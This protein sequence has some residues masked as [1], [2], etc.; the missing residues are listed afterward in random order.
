MEATCL[1]GVT[2]IWTGSHDAASALLSAVERAGASVER[3]PL[4]EFGPPVDREC[5]RQM[6]EDLDSF[7]WV[8]FT[9]AQAAR[10]VADVSCTNARIA[11]V[12]PST[13]AQLH[14]QGWSVDLV[15]SQHDSHGLADA[16]RQETIPDRPVLFIR[17]DRAMPTLPR[18][19]AASGFTIKEVEVYSTLPVDSE[20]VV[21]VVQRIAEVA[22]VVILGS[23]SGVQTLAAAVAPRSLC[24]IQPGIQWFCLGRATR[25][26]LRTAGIENAVFPGKIAPEQ[27]VESMTGVLNKKRPY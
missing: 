12:G 6:L 13:A 10:A 9:S 5:A 1:E 25:E 2:V 16:L 3:L 27:F 22:D 15:P 23:P 19:L 11:A 26:A 17:G 8:L 18:Q 7:S 24:E 14:E 21:Y 20:R 4:I